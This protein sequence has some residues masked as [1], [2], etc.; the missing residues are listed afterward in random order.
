MEEL[1]KFTLLIRSRSDYLTDRYS[2]RK[3]AHPE[4]ATTLAA[5][6][7]DHEAL[8]ANADNDDSEVE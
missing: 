3:Q 7:M 2:E 8:I 1:F 6:A 5:A 4:L